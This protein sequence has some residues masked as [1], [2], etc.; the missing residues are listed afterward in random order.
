MLCVQYCMSV[1]HSAHTVLKKNHPLSFHNFSPCFHSLIIG[2]NGNYSRSGLEAGTYN[3]RVEVQDR[4]QTA[5]AR[6]RLPVVSGCS[7]HLIN[8]G[9]SQVGDTTTIEFVGTG[10]AT[11]FQCVLDR[12]RT[13][14]PCEIS[15]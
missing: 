2:T 10:G 13:I 1:Q 9:V 7:S 15:V 8:R 14:E 12:S 6:R 4:G 5:V 11:T 3:L